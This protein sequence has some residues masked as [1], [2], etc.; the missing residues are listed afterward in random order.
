[1]ANYCTTSNTVVRSS[2]TGAG[3]RL[4][5]GYSS[6]DLGVHTDH[7]VGV[8]INSDFY[9]QCCTWSEVH[10][11]QAG[12]FLGAAPQWIGQIG[13]L[14]HCEEN[15]GSM[16]HSARAFDLTKVQYDGVMCDAAWSWR[17]GRTHQRRYL[18]LSISLR[19]YFNTVLTAWYNSDHRD[20]IH[21]DNGVALRPISDESRADTV[22]MQAACRLFGGSPIPISGTWNAATEA[23]FTGLR[24][25]LGFSG[26][27]RGDLADSRL[28]MAMLVA[29][30]YADE[31]A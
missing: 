4:R 2:L 19:R 30:G 26:D 18:A 9:T 24:R 16:H 14:G 8:R 23:A 1:M 6:N 25:Q 7:A 29:K 5:T 10:E 17:Q 11:S 21:F 13:T 3:I 28:F 15:T 27:I 20:H 22:L 31:S 12:V